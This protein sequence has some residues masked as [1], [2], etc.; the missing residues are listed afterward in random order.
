MEKNKYPVDE[1]FRET[2]NNHT[3]TPSGKAKSAFIREA[4][5]IVSSRKSSKR[6]IIYLSG[7]ILLMSIGIGI[8]MI[9]PSHSVTDS[10]SIQRSD[11]K[12]ATSSLTSTANEPQLNTHKN[13]LKARPAGIKIMKPTHESQLQA[14]Q[15]QKLSSIKRTT[16]PG[17]PSGKALLKEKQSFVSSTAAYAS[18]SSSSSESIIKAPRSESVKVIDNNSGTLNY[19]AKPEDNIKVSEKEP[20]NDGKKM[21]QDTIIKAVL[22]PADSLSHQNPES[23]EKKDKPYSHPLADL[24]LSTGIYII[25]EWLNNIIGSEKYVTNFGLEETFRFEKYSVR[26]GVGLS[27]TKGTNELSIHYNEYLG[28]YKQLDSMAFAWN[29]Q[30]TNI[31]PTY[32]LSDKTVWDSLMKLDNTKI[33]KRYT[34]LQIPLILGYDIWTNDNFSMGARVGPILSILLSTKQLTDNYDPGKNKII[35]INE[36]TPERIQTN[37]QIMAGLAIGFGNKRKIGIEFEPEFRYYF[38]SVYEKSGS[39]QKPWSVGFRIAF[40]IKY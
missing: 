1:L 22:S 37:W 4:T 19:Q 21:N 10:Q 38:N 36:I 18:L 20:V 28:A 15:I 17:I 16:Q 13:S 25:P 27:I 6:W 39:T 8:W 33:I 24:H 32:Y 2:L 26:T 7:I 12:A 23:S 3:I 40:L 30:H 29:Q 14:G 5:A 35:V 9:A 34:Y 11:M 31:I